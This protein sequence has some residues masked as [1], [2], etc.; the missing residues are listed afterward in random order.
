VLEY[1]NKVITVWK[2][3]K[4]EAGEHNTAEENPSRKVNNSVINSPKFIADS[5]NTH[6]QTAVEKLNRELNRE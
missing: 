6:F 4:E 2:I 1:D 5:F 3:V